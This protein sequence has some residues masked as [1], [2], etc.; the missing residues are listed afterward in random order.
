MLSTDW[1]QV[2]R[3][4]ISSRVTKPSMHLVCY[5]LYTSVNFCEVFFLTKTYNLECIWKEGYMKGGFMKSLSFMI[6]SLFPFLCHF[7]HFLSTN[8]STSI[9]PVFSKIPILTS[10]MVLGMESKVL[11][12]ILWWDFLAPFTSRA[13]I[14]FLSC[15][16]L[17]E[18]K[19][20]LCNS[21]FVTFF[22]L[23]SFVPHMPHY[24]Q[25]N[26]HLTS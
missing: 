6:D 16:C 1:V 20:V 8:L 13:P 3:K 26:R 17:S 9:D 2:R 21:T 25:N 11:G 23:G 12:S 10:V 4:S 18:T 7:H 5:V 15:L 19:R 14:S 22:N 24:E